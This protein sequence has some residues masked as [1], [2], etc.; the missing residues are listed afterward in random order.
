M[1]VVTGVPI[2]P[3][4]L[5]IERLQWAWFQ[6]VLEVYNCYGSV[7]QDCS[8]QLIVAMPIHYTLLES[9]ITS[10]AYFE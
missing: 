1:N 6:E 3:R 4:H 7:L 2:L 10:G 9:H 8:I 5:R